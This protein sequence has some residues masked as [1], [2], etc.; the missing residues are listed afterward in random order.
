VWQ[1]IN[2]ANG[3]LADG[4]KVT[5]E[6]VKDLLPQEIARFV[7]CTANNFAAS[8]IPQAAQV[9]EKIVAEKKFEDFLTLVAYEY[10]D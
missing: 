5:V 7:P 2:S 1:W 9:F 4:R 6:L 10:L 8:K 3:V